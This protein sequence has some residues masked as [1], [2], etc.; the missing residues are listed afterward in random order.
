MPADN[1]SD[2]SKTDSSSRIGDS[3]RQ[4]AIPPDQRGSPT[5]EPRESGSILGNEIGGN[6]GRGAES[7]VFEF[8]EKHVIKFVLSPFTHVFEESEGSVNTSLQQI[9]ARLVDLETRAKITNDLGG[10]F[11]TALQ[12]SSGEIV[13]IQERLETEVSE[14]KFRDYLQSLE[15][16]SAYTGST[17]QFIFELEGTAYLISDITR[18]NV[19]KRKDGSLALFDLIATPIPPDTLKRIAGKIPLSSGNVS[20]L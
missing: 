13:I 18:S 15:L 19:G 7:V 14:I 3:S 6:L 5:Q 17:N 8:G 1:D 20:S 16:R 12:L 10:A 4:R 11:S 2:E 9:E